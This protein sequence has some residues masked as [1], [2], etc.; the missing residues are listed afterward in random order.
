MTD[1]GSCYRAHA[2]ARAVTGLGAR[3]QRTRPYTPKHNGK[4]EPYQ[5]TLAAEPLYG[6][7]WTSEDERSEAIG[8]WLTHYN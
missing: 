5:R 1:N 7:P 4:V 2:F 6:H 3:H 8:T